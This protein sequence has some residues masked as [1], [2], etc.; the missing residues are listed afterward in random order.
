MNFGC[1]SY[2][3]RQH[4]CASAGGFAGRHPTRSPLPS[5]T[6]ARQAFTPAGRQ[7]H[8][9]VAMTPALRRQVLTGRCVPALRLRRLQR[10][11][12]IPHAHPQPSPACQKASAAAGPTAAN[13]RMLSVPVSRNATGRRLT[14]DMLSDRSGCIPTDFTLI[15]FFANIRR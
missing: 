2:R 13:R 4:F 8:N 11:V 3:H 9:S 1:S 10:S 14:Y 5:A 6:T 7:L 15:G 12:S